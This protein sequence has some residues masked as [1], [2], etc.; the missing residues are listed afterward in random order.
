MSYADFNEIKLDINNHPDIGFLL[1]YKGEIVHYNI[2]FKEKLK[3]S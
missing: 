1:D 2:S 3:Y